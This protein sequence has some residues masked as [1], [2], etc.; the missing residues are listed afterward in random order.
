VFERSGN[1]DAQDAIRIQAAMA[2]QVERVRAVQR[3]AADG[4]PVREIAVALKLRYPVMAET[5]AAQGR[6]YDETEL[7]AALVR[8]A[9]LDR[10]LKGGSRLPAKLEVQRALADVTR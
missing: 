4:L 6:N 3:L 7:R 9:E 10:A 1:P 5:A 8:L 2:A